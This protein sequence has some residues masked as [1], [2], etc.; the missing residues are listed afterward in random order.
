MALSGIVK[1]QFDAGALVIEDGTSGTALSVTARFDQANFAVSGVMPSRRNATAYQSRAVL[2]SLRQTDLSFPTGSFSI[3]VSEFSEA[4]AGTLVDMIEG[5]GAYA[6]RISTTEAKG[7]MMTFDVTFTQEG[8][9]YG[10]SADGTI[11]LEDCHLTFDFSEGDP[12]TITCN[13]T[14][15]GTVTFA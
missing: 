8:T 4:S 7:D 6:A 13:F 12:N 15:Y 11:T 3:M 14:C 5:T 10:D 2:H 9:T 1:T